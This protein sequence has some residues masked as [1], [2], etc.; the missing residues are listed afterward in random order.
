MEHKAPSQEYAEGAEMGIHVAFSSSS[1]CVTFSS[2]VYY[3]QDLFS[4]GKAEMSWQMCGFELNVFQEE[5]TLS[6]LETDHHL[7]L[8]FV[9]F[10]FFFH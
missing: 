5:Y 8:N 10:F 1:L 6:Q 7:T 4:G 2:E 9:T 3:C